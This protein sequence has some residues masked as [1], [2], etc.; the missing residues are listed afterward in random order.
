MT[1]FDPGPPPNLAQHFD[2]LPDPPVADDFWRDWGPVFY[3]GRLDGSARVVCV[4]S[5]PG[6]TERIA[7]RCLVGNAGQR[8][9]GLLSKL[10]LTRSYVCVNAWAYALHPARAH[11]ELEHLADDAQLVWRNA[12]YDAVTGPQVEAV[13]AFGQMAQGAVAL[14]PGR[15]DVSLEQ[16]PH[17]SSRDETVLLDAWRAAVV[18]LRAAVTPDPDGD[19]GLPNYGT[20]FA[21]ADHAAIPRRDLPF[22][23]PAFL[24]DDAWARAAGSRN[25]VSRPSPDDFHT[26]VWHAPP[27]APG[28]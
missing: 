16:I 9:Q 15:P 26:L 5:D 25:S 10:G 21:E 4:A 23:A 24:G 2:G 14:W 11:A 7:G 3:R 20:T 6:P 12:L 17:P 13:I 22:G 27:A 28:Q 8:V 1:E 19:A 18:E